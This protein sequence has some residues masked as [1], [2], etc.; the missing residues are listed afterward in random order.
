MCECERAYFV[1]GCRFSL[2]SGQ[3][4]KMTEVSRKCVSKLSQ[5]SM[6]RQA[7]EA[8]IW[9]RVRRRYLTSF[10]GLHFKNE[11]RLTELDAVEGRRNRLSRRIQ[12]SDYCSALIRV[13]FHL[14]VALNE[15]S[16]EFPNGL[17]HNITIFFIFF[18]V[19][20]R[21]PIYL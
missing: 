7:S 16:N 10:A 6:L 9:T 11:P 8:E 14:Y 13:F 18:A 19:L 21:W 2:T 12:R 4:I 17:Y 3:F 1:T 5:K 20:K 15:L